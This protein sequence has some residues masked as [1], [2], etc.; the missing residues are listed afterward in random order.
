LP[1]GDPLDPNTLIGPLHK[2][3]SVKLFNDTLAEVKAQG[4]DVLFGGHDLTKELGGNFVRPAIVRIDPTHPIV[5]KE[6]FAPILFT[7][8]FKELSTAIAW[9]NM[10]PQGLSSSLFSQSMPASFKF[11]S[12][13]GSD[14]GVI[15]V[16][17]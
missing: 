12:P 8:R 9:N 17:C 14:C 16:V 2:Q 3:Q 5:Q 1:I 15:N 6:T 11:I 4:G 13:S 10:V 7:G